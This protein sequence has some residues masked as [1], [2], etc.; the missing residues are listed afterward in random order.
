MMRSTLAYGF[1]L[2]LMSLSLLFAAEIH[3]KEEKTSKKGTVTKEAARKKTSTTK[4]AETK[5]A[6]ADSRTA[7][8]TTAAESAGATT[9]EARA[10]VTEIR[11]WSN[12]DYTRVAITLDREVR[13]ES[14]QI[15]QH[16]SDANP[17]RIY[18]DLNA[19]RL[20]PGVKDLSIGD[21]LLKTARV[22]QYRAD[23]V[24]VVLD[25]ENVKDYKVFP[26]SDPFRII[27]DVKGVRPLEISRLTEQIQPAPAVAAEPKKIEPRDEKPR[28]GARFKPGKIRRIVVDPGH[29]GHDPGAVGAHGT[30]EKNVVLA[31]G[32]KLAEKLRDEL[33]IDVVMTRSTDVFIPLEERTAIANK[34]N[35]DLFV[36]IHANASL[37][38]GAS[39]IE[40][41]YLNL[42]KTEKAAQLA[43]RENGTSLE[44]VSLLQAILFDL[45]ANYK[46]NDSAHLAE[47]VQKAL[48]RKLHGQYPST[49]NLGVKQGPFYVLVGAT[50]PSILVE[51]AFISN[52]A[53]EER[54]K[55][56]SYQEQ[57]AEGILEGVKGYISSL[58]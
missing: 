8:T 48:Y 32:L 21:G 16:V 5:K 55:D 45:M 6:G 41:Y 31:I 38:R 20:G 10:Q 27:I 9:G 35:A 34:V 29:G 39:G 4:A 57:A 43:A 56:S 53:E 2:V 18:I 25:V 47:E 19:S 40:T 46:L 24:R 7:G 12:P 51:T 13:F 44:K 22:G 36:S 14:N 23:V 30:Q 1:F 58:K 54:L 37:N 33:G 52:E 28:V 49:R 26:L 17:S 11:Y 50:M 42:A 3:A 15:K